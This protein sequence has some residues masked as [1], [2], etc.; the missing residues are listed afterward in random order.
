MDTKYMFDKHDITKYQFLKNFTKREKFTIIPM[1]TKNKK[2]FPKNPK[3]DETTKDN[4]NKAKEEIDLRINELWE[5]YY[6][7][8]KKCF[9]LDFVENLDCE[10]QKL[11]EVV[12]L[13][14]DTGINKKN[15]KSEHLPI[16]K[17]KKLVNSK[18]TIIIY[19][20][21]DRTKGGFEVNVRNK[22]SL[23][24]KEADIKK[25]KIAA[26]HIGKDICFI[27]INS[28]EYPDKIGDFQKFN[29]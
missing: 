1:R 5:T 17:I 19:Q 9:D 26:Y 23:L 27:V 12:F 28:K 13:D 10:P 8:V 15:I 16:D 11:R 18:K 25:E 6:D 24:N 29:F 2:G 20:H 3:I 21:G 14:P 4:I 22:L 7:E